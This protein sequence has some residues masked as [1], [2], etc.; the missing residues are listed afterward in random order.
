VTLVDDRRVPDPGA[1]EVLVDVAVSVTST[2]TELARFRSLPNAVVRYPHQPGFMAAGFVATGGSEMAAGAPV[3]LRRAR[4]QSRTTANCGDVHK[5][6]ADVA[7]VDGALWHLGVIAL[8]GLHR[9]G[10]E[11]GEPLAILGA[12][13]LGAIVRRLALAM[14]TSDCLTLA[15]SPAKRWTIANDSGA[16]FLALSETQLDAERGRYPL[17]IDA[18]GAASGLETSVA[19]TRPEGCVVLL[20]SPRADLS[21]LPAA[22]IEDRGLRVVGAHIDTLKALGQRDGSP[23]DEQLT[24]T[25]FDLLAEGVSFSDLI[26]LRDPA[27]ARNVYEVAA[28]EP[29]FIAAGFAW[30]AIAPRAEVSVV[31]G[32]PVRFALI[33]CGDIGHQNA[34]ALQQ[35]RGAQLTKV[36]DPV[37]GLA[38]ELA[39]RHRATVADSVHAAVSSPNVDAVLVATPHDTHEAVVRA[40]LDAGR[41]V[42]LEKPLA[43]D[44]DAAVRITRMAQRTAAVFAVLFPL[45][46]DPRFVRAALAAET[47]DESGG[48]RGASSTYVI[49]KPPHYFTGGFSNRS[50]STW[51]RDKQR[52]GGGVLIMNVLHHIDAVRALIGRDAEVVLAQTLPSAGHPEVEDQVS[53]IVDFGGALATFVGAASGFDGPGEM[54]ELWS[55]S[56]RISLLP[57]GIVSH[58]GHGRSEAA[59]AHPRPFESRVE[60]IATFARAV[61]DGTQPPVAAAD[62][63]AVQAIVTA[64][65]RSAAEGGIVSVADVLRDA[66]WL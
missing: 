29:T 31:P 39:E 58:P 25:F 38:A 4:H 40:A 24:Q 27:E 65:Y 6:P 7:L 54:I 47:D 42:L 1:D 20:G 64:G 59:Q 17:T 11:P 50:P 33:G 28:R 53:L 14:G 66:G 21:A 18:S 32:V 3:A 62:A 41:H 8:Y 52:S 35:A 10:Y 23:T 49:R 34:E 15:R 9:G 45:R 46:S 12:G 36:F 30:S 51:R 2:G 5:L 26:E 22:T 19:L 63:L 56:L 48:L 13:I 55:P 37:T 16:R 60:S 44:L 57:S 43:A 61:S